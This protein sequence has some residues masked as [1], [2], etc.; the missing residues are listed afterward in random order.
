MRKSTGEV[1]GFITIVMGLVVAVFILAAAVACNPG[2]GGNTYY[3]P[4]DH[5]HGYYDTHH[6]YHYYPKYNPHSKVYIAPRK[7]TSGVKVKPAPRSGSGFSFR[8]S[9]GSG[10]KSGGGF[11]SRR[12]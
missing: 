6:H 4:Q 2:G 5:Y 8:K 9:S 7:G 3:Y 11:S 12:R 10:Y 1:A